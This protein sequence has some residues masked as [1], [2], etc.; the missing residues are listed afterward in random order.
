MGIAY[1]GRRNRARTDMGENTVIEYD[2]KVV[3]YIIYKISH[4]SILE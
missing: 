4:S 1:M 3:E 2:I